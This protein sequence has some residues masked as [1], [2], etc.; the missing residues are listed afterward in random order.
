M[1]TRRAVL[2]SLLVMLSVGWV[3]TPIGRAQVQ[4]PATTTLAL[5]H[6]RW[7]H[8]GPASF[9]G[10]ID[11]VE[12][13]PANPSTIFV[14]TASGGVFK[15]VN[16]GVTWTPVFDRD[17]SALSI[18]DIAIAPSDPNIIW[19]GTGE[20]NNRQSSS[21][22]DGVYK[23]VDG[24]ETW[25]HM[26]L[27]ETQHIGR[28]VVH[29]KNPEIVYAAAMGHLWGANSQRGLYRT[30]DAGKTWQ[31]VLTIDNDTG[32]GD[33]AIDQDG[34]TLFASAYQRRRRGWGYV[35]GGP[36]SALYRSFDGGDTWEKL[37][38]GLP[39]GTLGRI[40]VEISPSHPNIV[41]ALVEHKT[42]GGTYRSDDRGTTW[43]RQGSFNPR[44]SYYSQIR[45]DPKNPDKVWVLGSFG[46]SIDAGKTFRSEHT[47]DLIHTDHHALWIDPNNPDHLLLGNDGG[48]Y[49]SYDGSKNWEFVDNLPIGQYYDVDVDT[50]DPYWIYGGTQDNGT[51]AI[52]TRTSSLLGITNAEVVNIAYGDGFYVAVDPR[53]YRTVYANSQSGRTYLVDLETREEQGLRPVPKDPKET[54]QFNW[55]TP[56]LLSP[57]DPNVVYYGGN[58]LFKTSD[59][60]QTWL[61]ISPDLS[62]KQDWKKLPLMGPERSEETLSRDDGVSDFGTITTIAESPRQVGVIYV[63]TDDGHVQLTRDGG[64]N[65]QQ[66]TDKFKLPGPRWVSRVLASAHDAG[67][68]YVSFDGH[69]DDDFKPYIFRTTDTG[70]TWTSIVG[71]LPDGMVVRALA[72][73][74][75]NRNLLLAGTEFGL[76]V[77]VNG[78]RDWTLVR[79]NLPRVRI[80]DILINATTNDVIL[81]THGRSI[82]VLDDAAMLE[83]SDATVLAEEAHLFAPR[84]ATQYYEMRKLPTPGAFKYAGPNP[85]YGALITY[86]LRN[87]PAKADSHV[88]IQILDSAGQM[89]RELEGPDRAGYNRVAW[90]LRYP[91]TFEA[92]NQDEGWFGPPKGTLV[93]PGEYRVK[94]I[95]RGREMIEPVQ[96]RIDP[97]SRTTPEALKARF[98]A[99][100]RLAELTKAFAEGVRAVE[101]VD[102]HMTAIK[103]AVKDRAN[104]PQSLTSRIDEF[105]KQVDKLKGQFRAGFNG[106]KFRYLDLAGQ[107][108]ASTSAPTQ[109]QLT[110]IEHLKAELTDSL[111]SV[112]SVIA[113]DLPQLEAELKANN[114]S[115]GTLQ[116]VAIPKRQ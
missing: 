78:G 3:G 84:P 52:P 76:F 57:H 48:L 31:N 37:T 107:L 40:G 39:S 34:R 7:R 41:Y 114:I 4:A 63:G 15:T 5:E 6:L 12:A 80:D 88:T 74:P 23:S 91:L 8:I 71:D 59:R 28:V 14:G 20:A 98:D 21:W 115:T 77:S 61:P 92:G 26:G 60:G 42:A 11:D 17:G 113:R 104:M 25:K 95:A 65:W 106:P 79:G 18:G 55:S 101:G 56:M 93:L 27:R 19:V 38:K 51:W 87:A 47:T 109:A 94:L 72:E 46:V 110:T 43:T 24:G 89:V 67:T 44:P 10:R 70:A 49:F 33:V 108:Q 62:R 69:Q 58:K 13:V 66:L 103:A 29:P 73:H 75:R 16:N 83:R 81:G 53:D 30:R 96:V 86:H 36:G 50:R 82:I 32:V 22:G 112:N 100:Q 2:H 68:A 85:D 99:S 64:K 9:G 116:P 105:A 90:D 111:T 35:G 54:Y 97:R 45:I 102:K 1:P